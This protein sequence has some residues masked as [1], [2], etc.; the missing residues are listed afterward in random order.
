VKRTTA[1]VT[2]RG[3]R[4]LEIVDAIGPR[5]EDAFVFVECGLHSGFP[6]CC[7]E[8]FVNTYKPHRLAAAMEHH[9]LLVQHS[10]APRG[11]IPCP[12]CLFD[13]RFVKTVKRCD[14]HLTT[15]ERRRILASCSSRRTDAP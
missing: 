12:R 11:Y 2:A 14:W 8:F 1:A 3:A 9:N 6:P 5:D 13:R 15:H 10:D 7:I 4:I